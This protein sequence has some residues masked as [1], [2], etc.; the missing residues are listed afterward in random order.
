MRKTDYVKAY[1]HEAIRNGQLV[2]GS[3]LPSCRELAMQLSVNKITVNNAYRELEAAHKVYSIPRGGFYLVDQMSFRPHD[4]SKMDLRQVKPEKRLIPYREFSHAMNK[5]INLFKYDLFD[6]ELGEGGF[7]LR[8]TLV[9]IFKKDGVYTRLEDVIITNGAQQGIHLIFQH[10]FSDRGKI[11]LVETPT[12]GMA[13]RMAEHMGIKMFTIERKI[14]GFDFKAL[15]WIFSHANISAFYVIPRHH[16]PTGYTL[17]EKDKKKLCKLAAQY[18][19]QLIEDDYLADLGA[20]KGY[21]PLH[22]YDIDQRVFYI[23]SFSKTFMPGM[24][25]GAIVLPTQQAA[26]VVRIKQ[27]NDIS[28]AKLAQSALNIFIETGMYEKHIRKVRKSYEAKL[29]KARDIINSLGLSYIKAH[30]PE[31]GIFIWLEF[32]TTKPLKPFINALE[33][34]NI[35]VEN[36]IQF[37]PV[38]LNDA[39]AQ[40]KP[41]AC[42][43]LSI[44]SL[45]DEGLELSLSSILTTAHKYLT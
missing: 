44:T 12:Y 33:K 27:I 38:E 45:S 39:S 35:F 20:K 8:K 41:E 17:T 16:N 6:Y 26:D 37:Y 43:R 32:L 24:R 40:Q 36:A 42:F 13:L 2:N 28:T 1:I 19:V 30:V 11:L 21:M 14:D 5:A 9:Q 18:K 3:K 22:Y 10:L 15:E 7:D 4:S 31:H 34:D 25:L 23:R 29:R